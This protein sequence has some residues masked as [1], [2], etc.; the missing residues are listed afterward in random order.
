MSKILSSVAC[1]LDAHI[2]NT[3]LPLLEEGKV[4]AIEWAFD[5]LY[6]QDEIP[7]W[8]EALLQAYSAEGRL[9]GHGIFFSLFSGKWS[10]EQADWLQLLKK[11]CTLYRFDH[12]TEHFGFMSGRD[13]HHGAPLPVPYNKT[14][15]AIGTD[16]LKRIADACQCAVG[17]ENL[18][19][20]YS[21][22]EVKRHAD[23]L[24]QLLEPVNGF[25]ILDLHNVYCQSHNFNIPFAALIDM[26]PMGLIREIHISGGSWDKHP[27]APAGKI[28][29]DTH[30]D[31]VPEE[32][33]SMLQQVIPGCSSLKFVVLEQL[34]NGLE[35][36]FSRKQFY[37]DFIRMEQIV[38]AA[39]QYDATA[40]S[41]L[42]MPPLS[43]HPGNIIED[44]I[45]YLQQCALSDI[46]ETAG[47]VAEAMMAL[48]NSP[49]AHTSWDI[50]NWQPYM[51]E[52]AIAIAQKWKKKGT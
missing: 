2:L 51:I 40:A 43:L 48:H 35:T 5:A 6:Q 45:L 1:N 39:Q 4:E 23:F 22:E 14:V 46:L 24:Q 19:F 31:A 42:L 50:E 26:Y 20:S 33:F 15:L 30:D 9:V 29:R 47:S 21:L 16:R 52:T 32:V 44:D 25:M 13:F 10:K 27:A 28:R 36:E 7:G 49:L 37:A 38:Q 11:A 3:C 34:G 18:A 41:K 12:I 8:F 17:L